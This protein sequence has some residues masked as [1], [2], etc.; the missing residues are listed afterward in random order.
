MVDLRRRTENIERRSV[1]GGELEK[2]LAGGHVEHIGRAGGLK[3]GTISVCPD[4]GKIA[5][6]CHGLAE[7]TSNH[8]VGGGELEELRTER[9]THGIDVE[10]VRRAGATNLIVVARRPDNCGLSANR[11]G[12]AEPLEWFGVRR[13]KLDELLTESW[14]QGVDVE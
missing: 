6:H 4:N 11:H 12:H 9:R 5:A 2:L 1:G 13:G 7:R 8:H 14:T 3:R 10:H